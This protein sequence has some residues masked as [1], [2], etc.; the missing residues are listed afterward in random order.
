MLDLETYVSQATVTDVFCIV[1][2]LEVFVGCDLEGILKDQ[3]ITSYSV[4]PLFYICDENHDESLLSRN[5]GHDK[6]F[7][8]AMIYLMDGIQNKN[9]S[10]KLKAGRY[11]F[12]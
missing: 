5:Q 3:S 2:D 4:K 7:S 9:K 10:K 12:L 6:Y 11:A 1:D 8:D